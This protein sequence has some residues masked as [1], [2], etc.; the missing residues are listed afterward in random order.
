[1]SQGFVR[2]ILTAEF[3]IGVN[4]LLFYAFCLCCVNLLIIGKKYL[5]WLSLEQNKIF[6]P[7]VR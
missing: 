3:D 4:N 7:H 6:I 1:M 2:T 5:M